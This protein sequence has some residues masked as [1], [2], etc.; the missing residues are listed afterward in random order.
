MK[1]LPDLY[2]SAEMELIVMGYY[3]TPTRFHLVFETQEEGESVQR[4]LERLL[5]REE[6]ENIATDN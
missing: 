5:E 1:V 6:N 2:D 3:P 4:L